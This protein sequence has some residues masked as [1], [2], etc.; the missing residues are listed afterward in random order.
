MVKGK[1]RELKH[2]EAGDGREE[3]RQKTTTKLHEKVRG[4]ET[5]AERASPHDATADVSCHA[6]ATATAT[7]TTAT[8]ICPVATTNDGNLTTAAATNTGSVKLPSKK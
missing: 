4:N 7:R 5:A 1:D 6:G 3:K 8:T 2:Q